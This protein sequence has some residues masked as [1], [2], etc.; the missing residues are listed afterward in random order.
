MAKKNAKKRSPAKKS[1][2]AKTASPQTEKAGLDIIIE[3]PPETDA[4][5][6]VK[7]EEDKAAVLEQ[8][9]KEATEKAKKK[10]DKE[11]EKKP[12]AKKGRKVGQFFKDVHTESKKIVWSTRKETLKNTGTV[13]LIVILIGVIIWLV[14]FGL[15]QL[16]KT[17]YTKAE[18]AITTSTTAAAS[19]KSSASGSILMPGVTVE[20]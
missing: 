19:A 4:A 3:Q 11:S 13:F 10:A 6:T 14:D 16:R 8:S 1:S 18:S 20:L 2:S 5:E 7:P 9:V 15:T 12:K 17:A